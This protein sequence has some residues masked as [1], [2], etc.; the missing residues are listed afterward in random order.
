MKYS[1]WEFNG[2]KHILVFST[3]VLMRLEETGQSWQDALKMHTA[4]IVIKAMA[5]M[6]EAGDRYA[7]REGIENAAPMSEDD[8]L[9]MTSAYDIVSMDAAM[10]EAINAERKVI[11]VP[12]KNADTTRPASK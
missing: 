9:D 3:R 4:T 1:I 6:M 7:R 2:E 8:L 5:A 10:A 12:P 11:A